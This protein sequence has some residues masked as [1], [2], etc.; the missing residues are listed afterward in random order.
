MPS[1]KLGR[2]NEDIKLVISQ[3]L[4]EVKDPRIRQGLVSVTAVDTSGDLKY[5]K[6]YLSVLGAGS[7]KEFM[8]GVRSATGWFRRE[9][10]RR[11]SLRN[12]PELTFIL[13]HSI[14]EGAHISGILASLDIP[15][16]D[17]NEEADA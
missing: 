5:C 15:E 1:K 11:L 12:T 2:V 7:E 14:E 10:A 16:D 17:G 8:K 3:L 6:I 4:R 9:L 13:D